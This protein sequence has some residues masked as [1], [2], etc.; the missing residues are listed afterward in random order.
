MYSISLYSYFSN[1]ADSTTYYFGNARGYGEISTGDTRVRTYIPKSGVVRAII[2]ASFSD[3]AQIGTAED[4][5]T[6]FRL[7][8]TTD[9]AIATTGV[10]NAQ[11][12]WLNEN[13]DVPVVAGD[14]FAIKIVTPAWVTNP[15]KTSWS[16][17]VLI[18]TH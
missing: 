4:I 10:S 2:V 7:N 9:T 3:D 5:T 6:Y 8:S 11:R 18:E 14:Y 17:I 15:L 13:M 12:T 1:P 16:A